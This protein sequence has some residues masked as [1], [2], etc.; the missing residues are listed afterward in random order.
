MTANGLSDEWAIW[1]TASPEHFERAMRQEVEA[2]KA[3]RLRI[4]ALLY[5]G[6]V[7]MGMTDRA[8][9]A[10]AGI[11]HASVGRRDTPQIRELMDSHVAAVYIARSNKSR[12]KESQ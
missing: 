12:R 8:V 4:D 3:A 1:A 10:L 5:L 2:E 7:H 9:A 6:R 11:A